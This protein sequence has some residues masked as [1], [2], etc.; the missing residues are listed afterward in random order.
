M[1]AI[2]RAY[3]ILEEEFLLE[4]LKFGMKGIDLFYLGGLWGKGLDLLQLVVYDI[5]MDIYSIGFG[6]FSF[7][8]FWRIVICGP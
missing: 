5:L 7:E 6:T 3:S 2:G 8:I 4:G 1:I